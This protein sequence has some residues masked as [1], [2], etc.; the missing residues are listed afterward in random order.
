MKLK[1]FILLMGMSLGVVACGMRFQSHQ[2]QIQ[3][4]RGE[5]VEAL[6]ADYGTPINSVKLPKGGMAYTFESVKTEMQKTAEVRDNSGR[7]YGSGYASSSQEQVRE[8]YQPVKV[9]CSVTATTDEEGI[10]MNINSRGEGCQ[11]KWVKE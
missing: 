6:I 9:I 10:I 5:S 8:V 2:E 11:G 7:R 3:A 4:Y 1:H